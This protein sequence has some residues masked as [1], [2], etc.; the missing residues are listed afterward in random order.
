MVIT[1]HALEKWIKTPSYIEAL[2]TQKITEVEAFEVMEDD[3][4]VVIGNVLTC[5]KH[6]NSEHLNLTTVDIGQGQIVSIVCGAENVKASQTVIVAKVGAILPGDFEIKEAVIRGEKSSGMICSLKE[7]GFSDK[8]IPE[9]FKEGIYFFSETIHPGT[10]GYHALNQTGFKMTLSVTPNRGDLLSVLGYA[11]DVSAMLNIKLQMPSFSFQP[12]KKDH[13]MKVSIQ[14]D[15]CLRYF[16]RIFENVVIKESPWWLKSLLIENDIRPMNN[17]VDITNYVLLFIG[18]PLHIFDYQSLHDP[19]IIVRQAMKEEKVIT[20]DGKESSLL[21]SDL[22]I[23]NGD[24]AIALA[25]VMGLEQTMVTNQ[26]T[27]VFLEAA[28]FDPKVIASTSKRL[29]LRSDASL[30]YERGV[31]FE[32]VQLGLDLATQLLIDLAEATLIGETIYDER[33]RVRPQIEIAFNE[34]NE[35]LGLSLSKDEISHYLMRLRFELKVHADYLNCMP[36]D[37][38]YD[39]HIKADIIEEVGRIYG[40]DLIPSTPLP[41]TLEG[42]LTWNQQKIRQLE[43]YLTSIGL[44][45]VITYTLRPNNEYEKFHHV[46]DSIE[47]LYPLS[48]DRKVLRQSLYG[49]MLDTLS[50]NQNRQLKLHHI[51]EIGHIFSQKEESNILSLMMHDLFISNRIQKQELKASFYSMKA[52]IKQLF[53]ILG[54]PLEIAVREN[55]LMYHPYQAVTLISNGQSVGHFGTLHPTQVKPYD[56]K[57]VVA[58]TLQLDAML[59][60]HDSQRYQTIS[61]FPSVERDLAFLMPK[62]M[63]VKNVVELMRQ[64][65]KNYLVDVYVFDVYQ[66]EHVSENQKSVAFRMI[67]NDVEKTLTNED[68]DK[69]IKKVIHRC[70]FELKLEMR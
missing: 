33:K 40:L 8:V 3:P 15:A 22:I 32:R 38:R 47:L 54:L 66:G 63:S 39:I 17:V 42:K 59:M 11:Y 69:L 64:T 51:F 28:L 2:T 55:D 26:T 12:I 53:D 23:A 20:L 48:E 24:R 18:T 4:N 21:E 57:G 44:Q 29:D 34:I 19:K 68:V 10:S 46:G 49:G 30:R 67:L 36:P 6:P 41:S 16:G 60:K 43:S 52:I 7:L 14:S 35:A 50:Y 25:G 70:Q 65:L 31:G 5:V 9:S 13:H 61:K 62:D 1:Q 45:Q 27:S 37:D 56:L 58:A